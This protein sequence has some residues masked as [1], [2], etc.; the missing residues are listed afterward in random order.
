MVRKKQTV[1]KPAG[2]SPPPPRKQRRDDFDR[3]ITEGLY[4]HYI[5]KFREHRNDSDWLR[6][7]FR[8]FFSIYMLLDSS[9]LSEEA[10]EIYFLIRPFGPQ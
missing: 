2:P 7:N 5:E 1:L 4:K 9:G 10:R 6:E 8:D 3:E